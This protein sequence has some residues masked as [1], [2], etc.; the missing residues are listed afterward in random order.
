MPATEVS[1][2][3]VDTLHPELID[4]RVA[5]K[6]HS[7]PEMVVLG[8]DTPQEVLLNPSNYLCGVLTE[9]RDIPVIL[10][11]SEC[12]LTSSPPGR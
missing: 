1:V 10:R 5:S 4:W 11:R 9:S 12:A 3:Y 8:E 2:I 7:F 6:T